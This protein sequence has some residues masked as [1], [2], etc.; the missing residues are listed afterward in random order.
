MKTQAKLLKM[1]TKTWKTINIPSIN[2]LFV[3]EINMCASYA[4]MSSQIPMLGI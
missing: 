4:I 1:L 2:L 3:K